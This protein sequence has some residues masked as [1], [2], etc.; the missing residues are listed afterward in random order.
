LNGKIANL[1]I[2]NPLLSNILE[3]INEASH[4]ESV[5]IR[6]EREGD[7]PYYVHED[8]HEL[9]I[10]KENSLFAMDEKGKIVLDDDDTPNLE[11]VCG[12]IIKKRTNPNYSFFT[13]KGSFW[14]N[15]TTN[16]LTGLT[17]E[18]QKA[19][20]DTRNTCHNFG[21]ESVAL[22][23]IPIKGKNVG[24]IQMNDPREDMLTLEMIKKFE[25]MGEQ[26][27]LIIQKIREVNNQLITFYDLASKI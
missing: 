20:G 11:C 2:L 12:K 1:N 19:V 23:P 22:I 6:L 14:T 26:V 9:F 21:Y 15:S 13:D 10:V 3:K 25:L 8:F 27:G 7:Y 16:L 17:E 5:A 4:F 18:E 24:L